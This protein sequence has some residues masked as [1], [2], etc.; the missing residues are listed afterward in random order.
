MLTASPRGRGNG[1]S[2]FTP[3]CFPEADTL[4]IK[5]IPTPQTRKLK[6][7]SKTSPAFCL[8][9][10]FSPPPMGTSALRPQHQGG[11]INEQQ[12]LANETAAPRLNDC[13]GPASR[14]LQRKRNGT[15]LGLK[16]PLEFVNRL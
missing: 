16:L 14:S 5:R 9:L 6:S 8:R 1:R 10:N 7:R 12:L 15:G 11:P 13:M 3:L 4:E 2:E